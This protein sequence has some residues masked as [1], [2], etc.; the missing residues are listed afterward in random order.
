MNPTSG[1]ACLG[2][3]GNVALASYDS[4]DFNLSHLG[5]ILLVSHMTGDP[6]WRRAVSILSTVPTDDWVLLGSGDSNKGQELGSF[7]LQLVCRAHL[8]SF[9]RKGKAC[10][11]NNTN[12]NNNNDG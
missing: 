1:R 4:I 10:N 5:C 2:Q 11:T 7:Y 3:L 6:G 12:I 8:A 9:G